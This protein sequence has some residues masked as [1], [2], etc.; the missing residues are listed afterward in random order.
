M[1]KRYVFPVNIFVVFEKVNSNVWS[2]RLLKPNHF[3]LLLSKNWFHAFNLFFKNELF[4]SNSILFEGSAVDTLKFTKINSNIEFF[5]K[6]NRLV[7]FYSYYFYSL[8]LKL[9]LIITYGFYKKNKMHSIDRIYKNASWIEREMSEMFGINY[10]NKVDI[11]KL[12]LDYSKVENPLLKDFP[13]EGFSEVFYD[14]FED[15]IIFSSNASLE[16]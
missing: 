6:K 4:F 3:F 7:L 5:F 16:L 12:L 13:V 2:S 9:D 8:K 10:Q 14:F 15:Q 11:R 1:Y